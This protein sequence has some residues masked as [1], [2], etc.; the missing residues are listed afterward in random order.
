M[1]MFRHNLGRKAE[2]KSETYFGVLVATR[3][4]EI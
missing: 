3:I 2:N 4:E 1:G